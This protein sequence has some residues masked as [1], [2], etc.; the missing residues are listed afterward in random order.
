MSFTVGTAYPVWSLESV[1]L[2]MWRGGLPGG[3]LLTELRADAAGTPGAWI[4]TLTGAEPGVVT[5]NYN[6]APIAPTSL[7]SGVTY[8]ITAS[9]ISIVAGGYSWVFTDPQTGN[10]T[11]ANGWSIGDGSAFSDD[12]GATWIPTADEPALF[13]INVVTVPEPATLQLAGLA[14]LGA[15][16]RLRRR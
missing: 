4:M 1:D 9:A 11:G 16:L 15:L 2:R 7:N 5:A 3:D 8:W 13:A 12:Q 10:D 6:F 14:V